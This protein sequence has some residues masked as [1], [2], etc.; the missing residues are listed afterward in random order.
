MEHH[1]CNVDL[2][3]IVETSYT[4]RGR[5]QGVN[6][7][8]QS[9]GGGNSIVWVGDVCYFGV[10]DEYGRG[11]THGVPATDHGKASEGISRRDMGDSG[12]KSLNRGSGNAVVKDLHRETVGNRVGVDG[13]ISLI[14]GV[15]KEN[16]VLRKRA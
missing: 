12:G 10:N 14:L 16:R 6:N 8:L 15:L 7:F 2:G 9:C 11:D 5:T 3:E 13:V 1:A 4:E